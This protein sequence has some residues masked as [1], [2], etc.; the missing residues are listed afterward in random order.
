M[1]PQD[2]VKLKEK[3]IAQLEKEKK[4]KLSDPSKNM[5]NHALDILLNNLEQ[6]TTTT[7]GESK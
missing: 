7:K 4:V 1:S 5:I 6:T 3:S 2:K